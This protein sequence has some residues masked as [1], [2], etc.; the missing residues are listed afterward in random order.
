MTIHPTDCDCDTYGCKLRRKG[1]GFSYDATP[2]ARTK[3]TFRESKRP[4]WEAGVAGEHRPGGY[5]VPYIGEK[6]GRTI[7]VKEAAERRHE[8]TEARRAHH[9]GALLKE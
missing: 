3:R 2:T 7:H 1:V 5:F 6:T 4:S 9:Q 8:F